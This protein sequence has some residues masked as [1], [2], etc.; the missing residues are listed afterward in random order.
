MRKFN[1]SKNALWIFIVFKFD[2]FVIFISN[3]DRGQIKYKF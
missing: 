1:A 2:L 3:C